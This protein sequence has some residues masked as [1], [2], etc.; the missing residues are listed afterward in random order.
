M[1]PG[2]GGRRAR[3]KRSS[4]LCGDG[5][6]GVAVGGVSLCRGR[7]SAGEWSEAEGGAHAEADCEVAPASKTTREQRRD[8]QAEALQGDPVRSSE[9]SA[10]ER[11][12]KERDARGGEDQCC[13]PDEAE[14]HFD[15]CPLAVPSR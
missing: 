13:D 14:G 10:Q 2:T 3:H 15:R 9:Q 6:A 11:E 4:L 8:V 7:V 1:R 5:G 12:C